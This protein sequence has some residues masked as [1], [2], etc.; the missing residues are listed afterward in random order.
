MEKSISRQRVRKALI[1]LS[2]VLLPATFVYISCPIITQGASEGIVTGGLIVF[3]LLFL[4]SLFLG[5]I[6]CGWLCPGGGLQEIYFD[7]NNKPVKVSRLD[8]LKYIIFLAIIFIPL[9]SAIRSAGGLTTI[10][11]FYYTDHGISIARQG[12]YI[13]FFVQIAFFTVFA[14]LG[15]KRG[16]CHYFCPIAVIMITG[17]KIRNLIR[18]PA[19]HLST[20]ESRCT[21]CNRCSKN[22]PM[23]LDVNIM[24]RQGRMENTECI[25]CGICVDVCP[26]QAI[27]YA[28]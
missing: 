3:I 6:W 27:R 10:D 11:F 12:A 23:G 13:I 4:S 28:W 15:G 1:I 25:L 26:K 8:W 22:C 17:R 2:F 20:I 18:W 7:I 9:I 19:L 14:I 5:R 16:F 21:D 24:V